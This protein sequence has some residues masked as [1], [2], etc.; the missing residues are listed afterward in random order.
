MKKG[1]EIIINGKVF[2]IMDFIEEKFA[3]N[4]YNLDECYAKPSIRKSN[5]YC[6][7]MLW[8]LSSNV[9]YMGISTYN[10]H[11]F[12]MRGIIHIDDYSIHGI[13]YI[14]K[15]RQEFYPFINYCLPCKQHEFSV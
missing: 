9:H 5:I 13:V 12:T 1:D 8:A 14:T 7:W 6:N 2:K 3:L 11:M 4:T 10:A 15:T